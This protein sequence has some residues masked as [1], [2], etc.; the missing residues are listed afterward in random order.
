VYGRKLEHCFHHCGFISI[1]ALLQMELLETF[2]LNLHR[3]DKDVQ[4]CDRNYWYFTTENLDKLR[5]VMCT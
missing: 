3:I 4:R 2:G 5:N 1:Y